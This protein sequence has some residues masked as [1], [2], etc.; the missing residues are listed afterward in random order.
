[1]SRFALEMRTL[2]IRLASVPNQAR[3]A[4]YA[5]VDDELNNAVAAVRQRIE[6]SGRGDKAGRIE[7]GEMLR[8]VSRTAVQNEKF[9]VSGD[10]G[11]VNN[12][13]RYFQYQED[14]FRHYQTGEFI[15][16]MHA[17]FDAF[18][19]ARENVYRRVSEITG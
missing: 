2:Q 10:F 18:L 3:A 19:T 7:S 5:I 11:W 13:E 4:A 9:S 1:M 8:R 12:P 14:G 6:T 16:G 15:E 17:V